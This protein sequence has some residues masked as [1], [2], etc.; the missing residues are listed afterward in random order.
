MCEERTT[1]KSMGKKLKNNP[2]FS[3]AAAAQR[4]GKISLVWTPP[5]VDL[6]RHLTEVQGVSCLSVCGFAIVILKILIAVCMLFLTD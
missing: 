6:C 4:T 5:F 1:N 2:E 3:G